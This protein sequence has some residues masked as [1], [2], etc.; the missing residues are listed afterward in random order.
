MNSK[1]DTRDTNVTTAVNDFEKQAFE[2][3]A[4]TYDCSQAAV[5]RMA[6]LRLHREM[7]G[8]IHPKAVPSDKVD[9]EALLN[10]DLEPD[11]VSD[12][13]K[14]DGDG[15][16]QIPTA[17]GGIS[18]QSTPSSYTPTY[19]PQDLATAGTELTWD[20]LTDAIGQHWDD[21]S[22]SDGDSG[23]AFEIHPDRVRESANVETDAE[24]SYSGDP[25]ALRA[26]QDAVAKVLAGLLRSEGD[27]V[28]ETELNLTILR[29]TDHQINRADY[30]AG[31]AYKKKPYRK[32][33]LKKGHI[34]P[35][36]DPLK[37]EYY[38]SEAAA[39][40]LFAKEVKETIADLVEKTGVLDPKEHVQQ[41][42]IAVKEDAS[43]WVKDL[44]E[45]RQG[46]GF[47]HAL[48]EDDEWSERLSELEDPLGEW[49]N[50]K[51]AA[52]KTYN[53]MLSE[54]V[55]TNQWARF[56]VADAVL[57]LADGELLEDDIIQNDEWVPVRPDRPSEPVFQWVADRD[58]PLSP[59]EQIAAVSD[60]L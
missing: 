56:A 54:Y 8:N 27:T 57:E 35:H 39:K 38:T 15:P 48:L 26:N 19:T 20:E 23:T 17:D 9:V 53:Q 7:F 40:E 25:Y 42:G 50:A 24:G 58:E 46:L 41:T 33:M 21:G 10:G 60:K 28:T 29:Y 49:P 32:L 52:G 34:V 59:Q 30:S 55:H 4:N 44:A 22:K 13:I 1:N 31:K 45:F 18:A 43:Q 37:D 11:D 51:V 36:P 16:A 14:M 6:I 5:S 3:L 47:L 12:G 2:N